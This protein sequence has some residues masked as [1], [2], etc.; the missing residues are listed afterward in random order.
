MENLYNFII[1]EVLILIPVLY[2]IGMKI[3]K[4]EKINDKYIPVLL[5]FISIILSNLLIGF[6]INAT[7]QGILISGATIMCNQ[8]TKQLKKEQK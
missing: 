5:M 4:M 2:I 8:F 7:L 1:E 6:G 3:K